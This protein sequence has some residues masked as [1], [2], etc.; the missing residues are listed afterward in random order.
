MSYRSQ[1]ARPQL[2]F[3]LLRIYLGIGL[4]VRG[5]LLASDPGLLA[6]FADGEGWLL[7]MF[8]AHAVVL[9]HLAGGLLLALGCY[10]RLAAAIQIPPVAGALFFVHWGEGLFTREQSFELA[11]L[12]LVML[13]LYVAFGASELSV[14][15]Y[16][17]RAR[18]EKAGQD[19][20]IGAPEAA[21]RPRVAIRGRPETLEEPA[22]LGTSSSEELEVRAD[23]PPVMRSYRDTKLELMLVVLALVVLV[24][25]VV[26]GHQLLATVWLIVAFM[27]FG[28][29]RIGRARFQ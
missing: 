2:G 6:Q 23:S 16:M 18:A 14:D 28:V 21:V 4:F 29:W 5:V 22:A 20:L 25:L 11:A 27:T 9:A 13:V 7:P 17:E 8:A 26:G 12:V 1:L 24:A 3:D 15:H 10:T 19:A